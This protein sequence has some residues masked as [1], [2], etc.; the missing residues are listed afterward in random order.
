MSQ[1]GQCRSEEK[2]QSVAT[3]QG[4]EWLGAEGYETQLHR[5]FAVLGCSR[6]TDKCFVDWAASE[7][8]EDAWLFVPKGQVNGPLSPN[9]C[10]PALRELLLTGDRYEVVYDGP[11]ATIGRPRP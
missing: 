9:D 5:H 11:G 7:G 10:C 3:V 8:L 6:S 4:S 2:R 1:S